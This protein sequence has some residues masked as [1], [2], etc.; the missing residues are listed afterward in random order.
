M[1]REQEQFT[2]IQRGRDA[3]A[4]LDNPEFIAAWAE[5]RALITQKWADSPQAD[6]TGREKLFNLL[7]ALKMVENLIKNRLETGKS[8]GL[9]LEEERK[10]R[11][12]FDLFTAKR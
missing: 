6:D 5:A 7:S 2:D 3:G 11:R 9:L 12:I 1:S 8:S 4:V 10:Q